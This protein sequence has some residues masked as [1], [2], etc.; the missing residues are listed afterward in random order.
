MIV[1]TSFLLAATLLAGQ[2]VAGDNA[3]PLPSG[4]AA[5]AQDP[6]CS[7]EGPGF[8]YS[9]E[10][11]SCVRLGGTVVIGVGSGSPTPTTTGR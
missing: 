7:N 5:K 6:R 2:A 11:R 1:R 9:P 3:I 4:R 10:A 8:I